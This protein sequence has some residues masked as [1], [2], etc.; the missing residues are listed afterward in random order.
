M[1]LSA[2]INARKS[3]LKEYSNYISQGR[4]G[5]LPFLDGVLKNIDILSEVDMG[6]VDIPLKKIRGTYTYL[7]S[8]SFARNFMP[9]M[10]EDTEFAMKWQNVYNIQTL[11]G[12]NDPIKVYE[13]LNWFYVVEGNKRVSVLKYLDNYSY[14]G[15][16]T[17]LIPKYDENSKDIRLY[18]EFMDFNKKT[19]INEIWFSKEGSFPELWEIIKDYRP[20]SR[21]VNDEDRFTYFKSAVY[22]VFRKIFYDLGG[23][24]LPITTGDAFLDFLKIHGIRDSVSD[25]E[26]KSIMK[27]F[28]SEMEYHKGGRGV[29]VQKTPSLKQESSFIGKLTHRMRSEKLKVGFAHVNDTKSSSWVYSHELG[30]MHLDHVLN[31]SVETVS[32]TRLPES[33]EAAPALQKMLDEGCRI[34]FTTSPSLINATLK[35]AMENPEVN[36]L[37]CSAVHSF[38]HVNT[39][40]GRIHEPRFLSGLVAGVMTRTGKLGYIAPFPVSD[41]LSGI[42]AFTL[43]ARMI[44]PDVQVYLEWMQTWDYNSATP[45][46]TN[47]IA[48]Q[49]ADIICHHNT[50]ANRQFSREYGVYTIKQDE[51]GCFVPEKYLAVPVWNWGIFYEKYIRSI[52]VGGTRLGHDS[53]STG[54]VRNYWWGMDSGLLDFFYARNH[55]PVETQK[56][57]E[58]FKSGIMSRSFRVFTGPIRDREGRLMLEEDEILE[59]PQILMM[60]WIIEGVVCSMPDSKGFD[61]LADLSTGRIGGS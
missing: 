47:R 22:N 5:Y 32:V 18:Y 36:L 40:F 53:A 23:D 1:D 43:G 2:Y 50:L 25:A 30:R 48:Q 8:I 55:I 20:T 17:R 6:I 61:P 3:G 4:N 44:R 45:Q 14:H 58:F 27:R 46:C 24:R 31:K 16:V 7:R 29:E 13:Y 59:H 11:E 54:R 28:I 21:L 57:I 26:L 35:V 37:N 19:G 10:D 15:Y 56:L 42:N 12:L 49:G 52:L 60:N 9:L 33:I 41:V 34:I 51:S 39:Y 38:K